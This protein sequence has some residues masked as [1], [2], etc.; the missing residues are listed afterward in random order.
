MIATN[1]QALVRQSVIGEIVSPMTHAAAVRVGQDGVPRCTPATGGI[2]YSH[3]IGDS[4]VE[5]VGDH[6]EPGV[7]IRNMEGD[8]SPSSPTNLALNTLACVGNRARVVTGDAKGETGYVTG[9]HGGINNVLLDFPGVVL[10]QLVVGDK[11]Q[12]KS[13]G[14]GLAL[15]EVAGVALMNLDPD[16]FDK[17]GCRVDGSVL[18]VPVTHTLPSKLMGSG[19]GHPHAFSGDIDIQLF[20]P[21]ENAEH[22]LDSLRFGD[23]V[24]ITD[25]AAEHGRV[26]FGGAVTVGVVIHSASGVAGHGPGVTMLMT[27]RQGLI[28]PTIRADANLRTHLYG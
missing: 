14:V 7:S 3:R 8:R 23:V 25:F 15:A 12:I 4:A 11:I 16:L 9:K 18:E 6:I 22:G 28:R 21:R 26:Y 19:W 2:T 17:L 20:D 5:L 24:A 10:D 13:W 1:R 27:S